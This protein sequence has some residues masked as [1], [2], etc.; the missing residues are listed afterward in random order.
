MP[1]AINYKKK[2]KMFLNEPNRLRNAIYFQVGVNSVAYVVRPKYH[3]KI[4]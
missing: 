4:K 1:N 2:K 3:G